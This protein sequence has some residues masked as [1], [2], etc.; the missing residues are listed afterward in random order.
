MPA[1]PCLRRIEAADIRFGELVRINTHDGIERLLP[2][3]FIDRYEVRTDTS[4]EL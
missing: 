4:D 2:E 3:I 1:N